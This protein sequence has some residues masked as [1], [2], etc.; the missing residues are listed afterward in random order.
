VKVFINGYFTESLESSS[1]L[2]L[3]PTDRGLTLGD[4]IFETISVKNSRILRLKAHL[5]RLRGAA[6]LLDIELPMAEPDLIEAL[7]TIAKENLIVDGSIRLTLTRGP[8]SRGLLPPQIKS[9]SLII[10]ASNNS[11]EFN[12]VGCVKAIIATVTRCNENSP[13]SRIKSL[14]YLDNILA[15]KEAREKGADDALLLNGAGKLTSASASNLFI[16]SHGKLVTPPERD[17]C[18][19]GIMRTDIIRELDVLLQS[20]LPLDLAEASEAFL[21]NCLSVRPLISLNGKKIGDGK[22]GMVTKKV[23]DL[24]LNVR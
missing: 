23:Q 22:I 4:G 1:K 19:S 18:L 13:L 6:S 5:D 9:P 11:S 17:G 16:V 7:K 10:T 12:A 24:V 21:T 2:L 3:D 20:I 8:S 14:N 15:L